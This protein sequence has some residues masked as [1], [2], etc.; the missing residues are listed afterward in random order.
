MSRGHSQSSCSEIF[1]YICI[2]DNFYFKF[3]SAEIFS[4]TLNHINVFIGQNPTPKTIATALKITALAQKAAVTK[5]LNVTIESSPLQD[6][7][8]KNDPYTR[9]I[10]LVNGTE[11]A[12]KLVPTAT[13]WPY[14][15]V[16]TIA[17][18]WQTVT[19][20]LFD[21]RTNGLLQVDTLSVQQANRLTSAAPPIIS[22]DQLGTSLIRLQGAGEMHGSLSFSQTAFSQL[23]SDATLHLKGQT[24]VLQKDGVAR[25]DTYFNNTLVD[26]FA[27]SERGGS[28]DR[29]IPLSNDD[30]RRDNQLDFALTYTPPGGNCRV[31]LH[32]MVLDIIGTST[33]SATS[34]PLLA[35]SFDRF[36]QIV[37]PTFNLVLDTPDADTLTAAA[38]LI[39]LWQ[40]LS[41]SLLNPNISFLSSFKPGSTPTVILTNDSAH[42]PP[43]QVF[44][45]PEKF[46]IREVG[47]NQIMDTPKSFAVMQTFLRD[48]TPY[49]VISSH[50]WDSSGVRSPLDFL[51]SKEGWY[52]AK[53]NVLITTRE[54]KYG[55]ADLEQ[56]KKIPRK[57]G[58]W[59]TGTAL[60]EQEKLRYGLVAAGIFTTITILAALLGI[61]YKKRQKAS[62]NKK[63]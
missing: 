62:V 34:S 56:L 37:L 3:N 52:E 8:P 31:G 55:F 26:S 12:L 36:P 32:N 61:T 25:L 39:V 9:T 4:P 30:L 22:F 29:T 54:G 38:R 16:S 53:G 57:Y 13:G 21:L 1:F 47:L 17:D 19:K 35:P 33:I 23:I 14:L 20:P 5:A 43:L 27:P 46:N 42:L 40:R 11:N 6:I 7:T 51:L 49:L 10:S 44:I 24:S 50:A 15:L 58:A 60:T 18:D 59:G 48:E 28:F 41:P 2:S 45:D 63:L